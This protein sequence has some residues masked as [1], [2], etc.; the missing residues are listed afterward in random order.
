MLETNYWSNKK[1]RVVYGKPYNEIQTISD[2]RNQYPKNNYFLV[3]SKKVLNHFGRQTLGAY[4]VAEMSPR[5]K[6]AK[7]P[8]MYWRVK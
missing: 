7:Q 2:L 8:V 5:T 6:G 4:V 3:R 1:G